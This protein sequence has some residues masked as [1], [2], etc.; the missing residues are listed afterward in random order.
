MAWTMVFLPFIVG[1]DL[2]QNPRFLWILS[3]MVSQGAT[4]S[5]LFPI[6]APSNLTMLPSCTILILLFIG[7]ISF[8]L[9]FLVR[10]TCCLYSSEPM[11]IISVFSRLNLAPEISHQS[12]RELWTYVR[13]SFQL[14]YMLVS[15]ANRLIFSGFSRLGMLSP[16]ILSSLLT[17]QAS[18]SI[19]MSKIGQERGSP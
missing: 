7:K 17:M 8:W 10:I 16:L 14:W 4:L 3:T 1:P 5:I 19:T 18:G 11:G 15:L 13:L 12:L 6:Q 9:I 2:F